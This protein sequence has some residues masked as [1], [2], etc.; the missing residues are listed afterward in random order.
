MLSIERLLW[1]NYSLQHLTESKIFQTIYYEVINISKPLRLAADAIAKSRQIR[2]SSKKGNQT[3]EYF[4][5]S[6][7]D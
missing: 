1:L 6:D 2:A 3:E 5:S 4:G 7:S